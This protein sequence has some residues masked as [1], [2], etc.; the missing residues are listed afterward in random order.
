VLA[1]L[2]LHFGIDYRQARD[3]RSSDVRSIFQSKAF[4]EWKKGREAAQK[5]DLAVIERLDVLTKA[6]G[7]L[8]KI[9]S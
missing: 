6:V 4:G 7:N 2:F 3:M 9:M 8:A 5:V 1:S